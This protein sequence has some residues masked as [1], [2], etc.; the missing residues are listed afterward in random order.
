[1][2]WFSN[3]MAGHFA[4][5]D[6]LKIAFLNRF[7]KEKTSN[8]VLTKLKGVKQK[9]MFV[10]DYS[11]KFNRYVRRLT[12]Q[13]RPTDEMLAAYFV[14]GLR[15]ELRNAVAGVDV[16]IGM[17]AL[18]DTA[19]RA[20]KRFGL[21]GSEKKH[22]KRR[23]E[24]KKKKSLDDSSDDDSDTD[25][26]S[27]SKASSNSD[28]DSDS[29]SEKVD[30]KR[31]HKKKA[32]EKAKGS[33]VQKLVEKKLKEMGVK[34]ESAGSK[35]A[36]CDICEKDGHVTT[37]CWYNPNYRGQISKRVQQKIQQNLAQASGVFPNFAGQ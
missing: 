22:S 13:E 26:D 7:W 6:A 24:K 21:S 23:K 12:A 35:K 28:Y 20:E 32:K 1:M 16:A 33:L 18:I 17:G 15:K 19:T 4:D 11:Q 5:Y 27:D 14:K 3:F 10:E 29:D 30:K 2:Q 36:H 8:D 34:Q 37:N 25:S 9:K 31:K